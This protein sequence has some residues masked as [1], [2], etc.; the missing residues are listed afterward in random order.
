MIS[1]FEVPSMCNLA[2]PRKP[3]KV[4]KVHTTQP[5]LSLLVLSES[6][7]SHADVITYQ[8][9]LYI[10]FVLYTY[11]WTINKKYK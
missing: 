1:K 4:H 9:F 3:L 6:V 11:C 2:N 7:V 8:G 5:Q 10:N